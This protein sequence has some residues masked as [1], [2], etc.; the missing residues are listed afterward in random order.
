[1]FGVP[2]VRRIP[3]FEEPCCSDPNRTGFTITHL[4]DDGNKASLL[5]KRTPPSMG[6]APVGISVLQFAHSGGWSCQLSVV[7][8][9][10]RVSGSLFL[11]VLSC[12][13]HFAKEQFVCRDA[14]ETRSS[15]PLGTPHLLALLEIESQGLQK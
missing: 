7:K 1:M 4:H 15:L 5:P 3:Q 9:M 13:L 10:N 14:V 8:P 12:E 6:S 2:V 11:L